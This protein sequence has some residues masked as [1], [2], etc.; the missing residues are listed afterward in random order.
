MRE[1]TMKTVSGAG[2]RLQAAIWEGQGR[3]VVCVHG[4]TANCRCWQVIAEALAPA[5]RVI[6]YDLRGR[7]LS[8]KPAAGYSEA[9]HAADLKALIADLGL[10]KPV[11]MGHSLGAYI[12]LQL[13][14]AA[15][16]ALSGLILLDGGAE[17]TQGQ[18]DKVAEAIRPSLQRLGRRY[19]SVEQCLDA[20]RVLPVFSPWSPALEAFFRYD[21]KAVDGGVQSRIHLAHI[22]EELANKRSTATARLY[23][24]LT[25]P[26]LIVRAS[27]G[28]LTPDDILLPPAA[29][30][31]MLA[32][33]PDSRCVTIEG[34]NHFSILWQPIAR[35]DE[36]IAAFLDDLPKSPASGRNP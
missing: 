1:P 4:L 17:L 16:D 24:R 35:R 20:M 26:V 18:W 30:D 31:L 2:A 12:S 9:V 7:G 5:R 10:D 21:L 23:P 11:L 36:A 13:A 27:D 34:T 29:V 8:D 6:A 33:I 14:A 22:R 15:P 3:A 28:L 19:A 25:C 32:R